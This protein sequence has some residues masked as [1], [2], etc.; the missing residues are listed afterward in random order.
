MLI[1]MQIEPVSLGRKIK[2]SGGITTNAG[3]TLLRKCWTVGKSMRD[4]SINYGWFILFG[5]S[6]RTKKKGLNFSKWKSRGKIVVVLLHYHEEK[7]FMISE[8]LKCS[9]SKPLMAWN[10][11]IRYHSGGAR[12]GKNFRVSNGSV[13]N[14]M[15]RKWVN[16]SE[17][18]K[19]F[20]TS[21]RRA[22][23]ELFIQSDK[24]TEWAWGDWG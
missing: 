13:K 1:F 8:S 7:L 21:L 3:K 16:S 2:T 19:I 4:G 22:F 15:K 14:C 10:K 11:R 5:K 9:M 6:I 18:V 20:L 24:N 23:S 17:Q 12:T